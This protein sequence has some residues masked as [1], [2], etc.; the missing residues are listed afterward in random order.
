MM[1]QNEPDDRA[2]L[3]AAMRAQPIADIQA[4]QESPAADAWLERRLRVFE[5]ALNALEA[6][7]ET[8]ARDQARAMA[9]LEEKLVAL[10]AASQAVPAPEQKLEHKPVREAP[11]SEPE[12]PALEIPKEKSI[13][14]S[15]A[16]DP[17]PEDR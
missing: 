17:L 6:R 1:G 11:R 7:A 5:R 14:P 9:Q 4:G 8:S 2:R 3:L 16:L 12:T 15:L 13:P 10:A